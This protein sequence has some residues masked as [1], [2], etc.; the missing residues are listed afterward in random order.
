MNPMTIAYQRKPGARYAT[1]RPRWQCAL[2]VPVIFFQ[3][4]RIMRYNQFCWWESLVLA[5]MACLCPIG[6]Q[7]GGADMGDT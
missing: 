4:L 1:M 6:A 7:R 2:L 5:A 3:E